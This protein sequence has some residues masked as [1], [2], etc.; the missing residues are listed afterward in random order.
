MAEGGLVEADEPGRRDRRP[1][2]LTDK[3]RDAFAAWIREEP[4]PEL[5]RFPLLL[6]LSFG[7]HLPPE[8]LRAFVEHHRT[9]H[10]ERLADYERQHVGA[11]EA[12]EHAVPYALATLRFGLAYERAVLDWFE[13]LPATL[14]GWDTGTA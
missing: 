10:E 13:A 14:P 8:R 6:T 11:L 2:R 5:I 7:R 9:A 4:G 3:G 12:G 1:Y